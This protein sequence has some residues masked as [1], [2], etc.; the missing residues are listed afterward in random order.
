MH[1]I[2]CAFE[3]PDLETALRG[4]MAAGP[5]QRVVEMFGR[6]RVEAVVRRALMPFVRDSG[7][8]RMQNRF[9]CAVMAK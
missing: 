5:S 9:R 6:E 2:D 3:Y 4:Q 7:A 1:E 8:V